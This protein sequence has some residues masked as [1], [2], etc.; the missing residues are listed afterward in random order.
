[1]MLNQTASS[2]PGFR[3]KAVPS[4]SLQDAFGEMC[5]IHRS[6]KRMNAYMRL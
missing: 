3:K 4:S 5:G 1:M 2:G 6:V